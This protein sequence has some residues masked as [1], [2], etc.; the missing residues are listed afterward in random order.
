[1]GVFGWSFCCVVVW[2]CGFGVVCGGF[3][4]VGLGESGGYLGF[5]LLGGVGII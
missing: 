1:M 2:F 4:L 5:W 3:G